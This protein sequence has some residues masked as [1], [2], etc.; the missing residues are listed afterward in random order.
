MGQFVRDKDPTGSNELRCLVVD[1]DAM[2]RKIACRMLRNAHENIVVD[3][4]ETLGA[5][6]ERIMSGAYE[7]LLI[8]QH[9]PDGF[10]DSFLSDC[11]N[12]GLL[13]WARAYLLTSIPEHAANRLAVP[14][15][16]VEILD[17]NELNA[18]TMS[19]IVGATSGDGASETVVTSC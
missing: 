16:I 17:K 15:D 18:E 3:C 4:V 8:D 11:L 9:L 14:R 6:R 13:R 10:G 1:D 19:R 12:S 2:D 5:A 7:I